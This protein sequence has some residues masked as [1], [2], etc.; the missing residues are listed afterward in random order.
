MSESNQSIYDKSIHDEIAITALLS[1]HLCYQDPSCYADPNSVLLLYKNKLDFKVP[2][3]ISLVPM[4]KLD[5]SYKGLIPLIFGLPCP[6]VLIRLWASGM[7]S[8]N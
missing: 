3:F 5:H 1:F 2:V 4:L 8:P 6:L 7:L